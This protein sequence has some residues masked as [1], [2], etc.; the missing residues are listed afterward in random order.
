MKKRDQLLVGIDLVAST[1]DDL[2]VRLAV[3]PLTRIHTAL[4]T[5]QTSPS[6]FQQAKASTASVPQYDSV[7]R[8]ACA[9]QAAVATARTSRATIR[10]AEDEVK[11]HLR[12]AG[13]TRRKQAY[14][15]LME[16]VAKVQAARTLQKQLR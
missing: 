8:V 2:K 7:L 15:Q 12:V 14:M 3:Q 5:A 16:V 9:L 1:E 11:R 10:A 6:V 13:Q 4:D